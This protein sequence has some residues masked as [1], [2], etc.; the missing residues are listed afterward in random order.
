M[1]ALTYGVRTFRGIRLDARGIEITPGA[2]QFLAFSGDST[3]E[4]DR[5]PNQLH[6]HAKWKVNP[7]AVGCQTGIDTVIDCAD[8]E[9]TATDCGATLDFP[10]VQ[11]VGTKHAGTPDA[12]VLEQRV[13]FPETTQ[14]PDATGTPT[15]G[16]PTTWMII[17]VGD[18]CT[19]VITLY[20]IPLWPNA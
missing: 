14:P 13:A 9:Q 2:D 20:K 19:E 6:H 12:Q 16:D 10:L 11:Y 3:M 5:D 4:I 7:S 17:P 8:E 18:P 15:I 1:R